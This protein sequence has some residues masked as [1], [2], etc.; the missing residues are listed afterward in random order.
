[1]DF[2]CSGAHLSELPY[3]IELDRL[4]LFVRLTPK[5]GRDALDGIEESADGK[6]WLKARVSAVPE[7]GKAN[8]ALRKLIAKSLGVAA[9]AVAIASGE[10]SRNK[11]IYVSGAPVLLKE[12]IT[13]RLALLPQ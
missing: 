1:L 13:A 6:V 12:A 7:D 3:R 11:M 2:D 10:T 8:A 9:G 5:G 4:V